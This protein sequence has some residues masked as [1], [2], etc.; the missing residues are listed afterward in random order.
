M[1]N[2]TQQ[3]IEAFFQPMS[4]TPSSTWRGP[5]ANKGP[6]S[7]PK[8]KYLI[9][10]SG[11]PGA[12]K[13]TLA[14]KLAS[15][16]RKAGLGAVV[17]NHDLLKTFFLLKVSGASGDTSSTPGASDPQP[18]AVPAKA[19]SPDTSMS[20][21]HDAGSAETGQAPQTEQKISFIDAGKLAYKLDWV[22]AADFFAQGQD[23]VI[24]DS[25]CNY[26]EAVENGLKLVTGWNLC[27][28][29][30][31]CV[32][33]KSETGNGKGCD[34]DRESE[35]RY[36]YVECRFECDTHGSGGEDSG[37]KDL[38]ILDE[39]MKQRA[40]QPRT[41]LISQRKS[42]YAGPSGDVESQRNYGYARDG[43]DEREL[44]R[45]WMN[46][47]RPTAEDGATVVVVD[48]KNKSS[49]ECAGDVLRELGLSG[50][51]ASSKK[52]RV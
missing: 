52:R 49:D 25:V 38:E 13:S 18:K 35:M 14:I 8:R 51:E 27:P 22:L 12:G 34:C 33:S 37:W 39:R 3:G 31:A 9:Q 20:E 44:F 32:G 19:T 45:K 17:V 11:P 41:V 23:V 46:P 5:P 29:P 47:A 15:E 7:G 40:K 2:S 6:S 24:V 26:R 16:M 30:A 10:M 42:V 43:E 4:E 48:S 21:G 28:D 36:V 1:G 50:S